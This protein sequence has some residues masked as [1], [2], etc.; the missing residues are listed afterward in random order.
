M[1]DRIE[2]FFCRDAIC[3]EMADAVEKDFWG[4]SEQY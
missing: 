1:S 2:L 3:P 4:I